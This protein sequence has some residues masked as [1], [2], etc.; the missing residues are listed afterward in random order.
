L[1]ALKGFLSAYGEKIPLTGDSTTIMP[2]WEVARSRRELP[3]ALLTERPKSS[4]VISSA[5]RRVPDL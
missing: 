3:G 5:L 1:G 4:K 2:V